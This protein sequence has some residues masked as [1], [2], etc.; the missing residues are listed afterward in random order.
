MTAVGVRE[1]KN[2]LSAFLRRVTEGE[3]IVVTDRGRPVE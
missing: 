2:R 1:L 3:R